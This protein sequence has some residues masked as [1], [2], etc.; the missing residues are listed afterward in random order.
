MKVRR[1]LKALIAMLA[2]VVTVL[3]STLVTQAAGE[4]GILW[5]G[6]GV[7]YID[8]NAYPYTYYKDIP[9]WGKWAYTEQGCA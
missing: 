7:I 6:T 1:K 3:G 9:E 2:C 8:I 5:N 4:S